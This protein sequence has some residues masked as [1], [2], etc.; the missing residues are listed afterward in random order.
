MLK[1]VCAKCGHSPEVKKYHL[2]CQKC[3]GVWISKRERPNQ[4][5]VCHSPNWA[6]D[7]YLGPTGN[8]RWKVLQKKFAGVPL[9]VAFAAQDALLLDLSS[10]GLPVHPE[11]QERL[12]QLLAK[13]TDPVTP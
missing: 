3:N 7:S 2:K 4:C 12:A 11:A 10:H 5:P 1:Y 6:G 13:K 9:D 8:I